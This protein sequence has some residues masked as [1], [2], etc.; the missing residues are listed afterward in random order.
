VIP[1]ANDSWRAFAVLPTELLPLASRTLTLRY[2]RRLPVCRW[3]PQAEP[4]AALLSSHFRS[5][6][7]VPA[8]RSSSGGDRW[9]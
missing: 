2:S 1:Y 3:F 5:A 8:S 4:L 7:T 9:V 6:D